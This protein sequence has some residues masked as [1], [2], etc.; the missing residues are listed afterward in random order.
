[1]KTDLSVFICVHLWK[2]FVLIFLAL[3]FCSCAK[4]SSNLE[5]EPVRAQAT[6]VQAVSDEALQKAATEALGER[7]GVVIV[8]DPQN[9]RLRALV[10]DRA[11]F[12]QT[13]P[14]GSAIKPFTALAALRAGTLERDSKHKCRTR[15]A[16][17]GYEI[18][19]T[20]PVS[21]APFNLA[22]ALAYSCND[23]FANVGERL[24]EGAFN[25][26]LSG[27]G[28]GA[29]TGVS[30]AEA[31]GE[32]PRGD[33]SVQAAL[34]DSD[35]LLATPIQLATAYAALVNGG[36]LHRPQRSGELNLIPQEVERPAVSLEHRAILIDGMR[37]AVKYGTA[38]KAGLGDL[39]AYVFGKTGT[40][41]ASNGFRTQGWFVGFVAEKGPVGPPRPEQVHLEVLVFLRR[42]HGA[43]C[44]VVAKA[45]LELAT[46]GATTASMTPIPAQKTPTPRSSPASGQ[47]IKVYST[48]E[49]R[50]YELSLEEY[51]L[52]VVSAEA[53]IEIEDEAL[54]AQAIV[55]RTYALNNL[56]RHASDRYDFCSL[57]H[58]QQYI[59]PTNA[60]RPAFKLAVEKTAG[61]SL[62]LASGKR[63]EVYFHAA[64]GG[65]TANIER[66]WGSPSPA[67]PHLMGVRDDFC[68]AAPN[69][70]WSQTISRDQLLKALRSDERSDVGARLDGVIVSK[71]DATGRAEVITLEGERRRTI[72]GWD[73]K[74]I[75]GRALGWQMI[76]SSLFNVSRAGNSFVFRGGGFGHGLGLCQ[77]GAH[78]MA[79]RGMNS[80]RILEYYFPGLRLW[81][82]PS[83]QP[84]LDSHP[85]GEPPLLQASFL[86]QSKTFSNEHF[87][88]K[89][90]GQVDRPLLDATVRT[91][92]TART[93]VLRRIAA[94]GLRFPQEPIV[95]VV[96]HA[97]TADFIAATGQSGWAAGVTRGRKIELQPPTLLQKRGILNSTLRHEL[98]HALI[99]ILGDG[100]TPRWLAEGLCIH[101]AGEGRQYSQG[102]VSKRLDVAELE[103]RLQKPT[104]P[105]ES[106]RLYAMAYQQVRSMIRSQGEA[107]VWKRIA[108][109]GS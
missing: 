43:D 57:T 24:S 88:F 107:A 64:C 77:S 59:A 2:I 63:A 49:K 89:A 52:G 16:R 74:I 53:S 87:R 78:A 58:C 42:A 30:A 99:E 76:K 34:G 61:V 25:A 21:A 11:A 27:F 3:L 44:A 84:A 79:K 71:R 90:S 82:D 65:V 45:I 73:F 14:P 81:R 67:P 39:P 75:V 100:R 108:A 18:V 86:S 4:Q 60:L 95:D 55:S 96:L 26:T 8:L 23:Y 22:Q 80:R 48:R 13:Y 20:H 109:P 5:I 98:S 66:L 1:M 83:L 94:S 50:L 47:I 106:R 40:S 105:E 69:R 56:K 101:I 17:D 54:Q 19:C 12:E 6:A 10:H 7:E 9:G 93:D 28:F 15:Y 46:R 36:R 62:A 29:R 104:S 51:L 32:L 72:R 70:T 33:W 68:A 38:A 103:R 41:T 37:G 102:P 31:A 91:L 35:R 97:S 92:E 85:F